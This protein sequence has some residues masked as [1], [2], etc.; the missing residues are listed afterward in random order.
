MDIIAN[1]AVIIKK[2]IFAEFDCGLTLSLAILI[3]ISTLSKYA[4]ILE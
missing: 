2:C 4:N 3:A 1:D